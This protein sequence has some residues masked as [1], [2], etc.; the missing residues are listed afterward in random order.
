M[1]TS[2]SSGHNGWD[3]SCV[4]GTEVFA[5][6]PGQ[7]VYSQ[8]QGY[9]N[10]I[11][12]RNF[13][14]G[15]EVVYAHLEKPNGEN[16]TVEAGELIAFSDNTGFS[17]GPHLHIGVKR[18]QLRPD[19]SGFDVLNYNNGFFGC[20]DPAT[21]F[22]DDVF[23]LPVDKRYGFSPRALGIPSEIAFFPSQIYFW[24]T[25]KRLM[26]TREYNALRY[27]FWDLRTV[28]DPAMFPVWSEM[29][30]ITARQRKII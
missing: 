7:M 19:N 21:Y 16:R 5:V 6:M 22:P 1:L 27:G 20:V 10:E 4:S 25:Q 14:A 23:D 17:T 3:L 13:D 8:G 26:T 18:I 24:R 12:L 15:L 29:T 30:K 9:G 28:L 2:D 11:R